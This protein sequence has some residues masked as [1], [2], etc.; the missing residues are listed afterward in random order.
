MCDK[1]KRNKEGFFGLFFPYLDALGSIALLSVLLLDEENFAKTPLADLLLNN[2][3]LLVK[4]VRGER[5]HVVK[6]TGMLGF[7]AHW[8]LQLRLH[9][10]LCS[11]FTR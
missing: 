2:E 7:T 1:T 5:L 3:A 10:L 4:V 11:I 9:C 8:A 6:C